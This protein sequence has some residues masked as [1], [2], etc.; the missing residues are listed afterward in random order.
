MKRKQFHLLSLIAVIV[1]IA[2][3]W[4]AM[5]IDLDGLVLYL[6][7]EE[8]GNPVDHSPSPADVVVK[9]NLG[10]VD[11]KIGQ[12]AE[13]DGSSYIEVVDADKLDGMEALTIE[14]WMMLESNVEGMAIASKRI[15][16]QNEDAYNLFL[17]TGMKMS[18]RVNSSADFWSQTAFETGEWYHVAYVFDGNAPDDGKQKMYVDG[19]LESQGAH[20]DEVVPERGSSLWIGELDD[21]RGFIYSGIMDELRIWSKALSEEEIQ[22][23][24]TGKG[25]PVEP[26]EKLATIWGEMKR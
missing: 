2:T 5:A 4:N 17:W 6:S 22:S 24:M 3:A 23:F 19:E 11:G 7:F 18:G 15:G 16:H 9:G 10:Q 1:A 12:A 21:G 14:V 25:M 20:P 26:Q 13:F 8:A